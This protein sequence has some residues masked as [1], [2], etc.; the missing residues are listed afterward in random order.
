MRFGG[1]VKW[2]TVRHPIAT[3]HLSLPKGIRL[4]GPED[5]P[6]E[7]LQ[8]C[9][10]D[11]E[12]DTVDVPS[13]AVLPSF[14]EL[15]NLAKQVR[16]AAPRRPGSRGR[17]PE[18]RKRLRRMVEQLA[19]AFGPLRIGYD[20]RPGARASVLRDVEFEHGGILR[21]LVDEPTM[22]R[23]T[24]GARS[25]IDL[26]T[27]RRDDM[28]TEMFL[29]QER[30]E[31]IAGWIRFAE[32]A[33][34]MLSEAAQLL[35]AQTPPPIEVS[36]AA[37]IEFYVGTWQP[38]CQDETLD[39]PIAQAHWAIDP[40]T[41]EI[42]ASVRDTAEKA[43]DHQWRRATNTMIDS[44]LSRTEME[45]ERI[46]R[47]LRQELVASRLDNL[48]EGASLAPRL[49][50]PSDDTSSVPQLLFAPRRLSVWTQEE[51]CW[52]LWSLVVAELAAK[53]TRPIGIRQC[54]HCL[55]PFVPQGKEKCCSEAC[56]LT[57]RKEEKQRDRSR[58]KH[59]V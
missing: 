29:E 16:S 32:V 20:G 27:S 35:V 59:G 36:R 41:W 38:L 26:P 1:I 45:G 33:Q 28:L 4:L 47:R 8:L 55:K 13:S 12:L 43:W 23:A 44:G 2:D 6:P 19:Q 58:L 15:A 52:T 21:A 22:H 50:W 3:V 11:R 48:I 56:K 5:A 24:G 14:V 40:E 39:D 51:P 53:I 10:R 46:G 34:A 18:P 17:V 25:S 49:T 9:W 54:Q 31:P 57:H 7:S 37:F 30:T 42:P